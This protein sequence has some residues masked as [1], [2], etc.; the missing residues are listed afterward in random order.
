MRKLT[1]EKPECAKCLYAKYDYDGEKETF[2]GCCKSEKCTGTIKPETR[3]WYFEINGN[4][5]HFS[6]AE[7][8]RYEG[9]AISLLITVIENGFLHEKLHAGHCA[10]F[11]TKEE[12]RKQ[13]E[14]LAKGD[15]AK[16]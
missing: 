15:Y 4:E 13:C 11:L 14:N 7:W 2:L 12:A 6:Q 9:V 10:R 8:L 16:D 3:S 5:W 1:K